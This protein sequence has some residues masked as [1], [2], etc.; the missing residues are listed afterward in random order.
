M[1]GELF[2][3]NAGDVMAND[4]LKTLHTALID[5]RAGYKDAKA[6]ADDRRTETLFVEAD[7]GHRLAHDDIHARLL[8]LG[9]QPDEGGS[10]MSTIH[11]AVI[12][13]R[14]AVTGLDDRTL[15]SFASGEERII[16]LYDDAIEESADPDLVAS[17][18][19]HRAK[20]A[21]LVAK[22]KASAT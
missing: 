17:L 8:Q 21:T 16:D 12:A 6:R 22:M 7:T 10:F 11:E 15:P 1:T 9:E 3:W 18:R 19:I 2:E 14:S 20:L 5:A 4:A 13:I